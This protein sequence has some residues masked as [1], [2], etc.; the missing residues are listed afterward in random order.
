MWKTVKQGIGNRLEWKLKDVMK[1]NRDFP[2]NNLLFKIH[3]TIIM[4]YSF[5]VI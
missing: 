1:N 4:L 3:V 5:E 2:V